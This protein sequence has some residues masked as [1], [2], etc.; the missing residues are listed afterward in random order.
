MRLRRIY[1]Y[2]YYIYNV[3]LLFQN[4][5]VNEY[6]G[7]IIDAEEADKR[8]KWANENNYTD[9]YFMVIDN[10]KLID[11]RN[12]SNLSRFMNHSCNPNLKAEKWHVNGDDR[13]GLFAT[14]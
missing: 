9:F 3:L 2:I 5:L 1:I 4:Q 10:N 14:R 11:A 8:T 13:I 7:E 12:C 6:V